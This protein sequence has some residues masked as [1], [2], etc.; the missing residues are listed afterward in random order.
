VEALNLVALGLGAAWASGINLY[1]AVLILGGL[2]AAGVVDLP[3]DLTVL[4]HPAVLV[5]AGGLYIVE[6]VA[7]KVP[8]VDSAWDALHTFIRIPAGALL[9]A[10]ALQDWGAGYEVAA[11]LLAGGTLAAASHATKASGRVAVNTSPEP[12]SNWLVSLLEDGLV[13]GGLFLALFKPAL[14]LTLLGVFA[15]LVIW[16]LPKLWRA[17]R[18]LFGG[19]KKAMEI[20]PEGEETGGFRVDFSS[21]RDHNDQPAPPAKR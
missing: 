6:F 2:G 13:L 20:D 1:L 4:E 9:A 8:G 21:L 12:F 15:L 19:A 5:A 14:F 18:R 17:L 16:L 10:G 3:G 7:D 11:A